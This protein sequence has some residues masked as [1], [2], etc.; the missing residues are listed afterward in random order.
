VS[1]APAVA[2]L[3]PEAASVLTGRIESL[4]RALSE[5]DSTIKDTTD[6]SSRSWRLALSAFALVVVIGT[7]VAARLKDD[8]RVASQRAERAE[9]AQA[10]ATENAKKQIDE[11]SRTAAAQIADASK[12]AAQAQLVGDI[13]AAPDLVQFTLLGRGALTGLTAVVRVSGTHGVVFSGSL[14]PPPPAGSTYQLWLLSRAGATNGGTF[15]PNAAGAVTLATPLSTALRSV[16]AALV[17]VEPGAGSATPL[18]QP[19]LVRF[20]APPA[21]Q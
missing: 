21:Q 9:Q 11:V 14:L 16:S 2:G 15:V 17:T 20:A 4:E 13:L 18:G 19:V 7:I 5:R 10:T 12:R 3:L 8:V 6:R 1:A